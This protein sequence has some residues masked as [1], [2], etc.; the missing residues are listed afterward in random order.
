MEI[1]S[2]VYSNYCRISLILLLTSFSFLMITSYTTNIQIY[3]P[4]PFYLFFNLSIYYWIGILILIAVILIRINLNLGISKIIQFLDITILGLATC[5]YSIITFIYP[6]IRYVDAYKFYWRLINPVIDAGTVGIQSYNSPMYNTIFNASTIF[7]SYIFQF[8]LPPYI[9][10]N[11]FPLL[12]VFSGSIITYILS[13]KYSSQYGVIG[14]IVFLFFYF[15]GC[16][17]APQNFAY[18]PAFFILFLMICLLTTGKKIYRIPLILLFPTVIFSH[19]L[20]NI[21]LIYSFLGII[22]LLII[23][24]FSQFQFPSILPNVLRYDRM[25]QELIIPTFLFVISFISYLIYT[26][27]IYFKKLIDFSNIILASILEYESEEI[28]LV[29]RT[30]V[31]TTPHIL[32]IYDYQI[33]MAIL[34]LYLLFSII[35]SFTILYLYSKK[36]EKIDNFPYCLLIIIIF[37]ITF[38]YGGILILT[39]NSFYGFERSYPISLI[40]LGVLSTIFL[41]LNSS[42]NKIIKIIRSLFIVVVVLLIIIFPISKYGSDP[43]HFFSE[44]EDK[45]NQ[46]GLTYNEKDFEHLNAFSNMIYNSRVLKQQGGIKYLNAFENNS[47]NKIYDVG[48]TKQIY[49]AVG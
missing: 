12:V 41:S 38:S 23:Y 25:N 43:Y 26:N 34:F 14:G 49:S 18:I 15:I 27:I 33:R 35:F 45:A 42:S 37:F 48:K 20:T 44:S 22:V 10:A 6:T 47:L 4:D 39:G 21:I 29:H 3:P 46:F 5:Y 8:N 32:Y 7:F 9:I 1:L 13:S 2:K 16:H 31:N 19:L 40:P 17:L 11:T 24:K 36:S 28:S 30:V